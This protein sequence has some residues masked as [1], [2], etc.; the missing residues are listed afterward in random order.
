MGYSEAECEMAQGLKQRNVAKR[1][2]EEQALSHFYSDALRRKVLERDALI[3]SM[4]PEYA[5]VH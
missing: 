4:F 2:T 5:E 1:K 3:F